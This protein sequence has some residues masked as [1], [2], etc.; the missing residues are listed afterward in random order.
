MTMV[1]SR[2]ERL[3]KI[4]L[5]K[6]MRV[7]MN[8]ACR[9]IDRRFQRTCLLALPVSI[10]IETTTRCNLFCPHCI[11]SEWDRRGMDMSI[12]DFKRIVN[13]FPCLI[14]INLQGIGEPLLN[15]N[16]FEMVRYCKKKGVMVYFTTNGTIMRP[17]IAKD[18]VSSGV[19]SLAFSIDGA[20][21][22]TFGESKR[23]AEFH[24][25]IDNIKLL[26]YARGQKSKPKV[27]FHFVA[28]RKNIQELGKIIDLAAEVGVDGV[29]VETITF[30][31]KDG[32]LSS[33]SH[34]SIIS[35]PEDEMQRCIDAARVKA[36]ARGL[37]FYCRGISKRVVH[38]CRQV[39]RSCFISVDGFVL[40]CSDYPDP[41][42]CGAAVGNLL[43][44]P[45]DAIWNND[46]YRSVRK[47]WYD[48]VTPEFCRTCTKP[49]L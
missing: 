23:G 43:E 17:S 9:Q 40:L 16:L 27:F 47:A 1:Y 30:W 8:E 46:A 28:T 10:Q 18:I 13:Q 49:Y 14:D 48:G 31:G 29:D 41:R 19:D 35:D 20:T 5:R 12:P 22:K 6:G 38:Q 33:F 4:G 39:F 21:E 34:I 15:P 44:Q 7:F 25:V 2:R 45:F 11:S 36:R 3:Q 24:K 37:F 32:F 42:D 26:L